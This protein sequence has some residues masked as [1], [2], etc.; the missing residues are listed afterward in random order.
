MTDPSGALFG[1]YARFYDSLY[2]DKDYVA[3]SEYLARSLRK[4][5]CP[6]GAS[7]LDLGCGTGGHA[8]LLARDGY[9]VTGV[10]R[11]P[12]MIEGARSK[13]AA[14]QANIDLIVGD[15]RSLDLGRTFNA[16][17]AMFAVIGYQ[18][19]NDD[20][21]AALTTARKHLNPG[22]L[23][24][25]D[26]WFGPAVLANKPDARTKEVA[27]DDGGRLVRAATP[28]MDVVAQTV[29][30]DYR[31]DCHRDGCETETT[32][33]SH[34]MRFL[35][36]QEISYLLGATG[37]EV[38]SFTP[39]MREGVPTVDDWNVSWIARAL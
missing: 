8:I 9:E 4:H 25:F 17:I 19:T 38:V 11:S 31:L 18:L 34:T 20:L 12:E 37:F 7:I 23:F 22:G 35:F 5:G 16:V 26:A 21:V 6:E 3:E 10:D 33:E 30:V 29:R 32:E 39:F 28:F 36:A 24:V 1:E 13:A 2:A 14:E 27:L 15:M